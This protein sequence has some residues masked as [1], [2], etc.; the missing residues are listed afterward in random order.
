M[1]LWCNALHESWTAPVCRA[2]ERTVEANSA[3]RRC[4]SSWPQQYSYLAA[5]CGGLGDTDDLHR[6]GRRHCADGS[7]S[8]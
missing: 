3:A 6:V 8:A 5:G 1:T 4:P 2:K 7:D